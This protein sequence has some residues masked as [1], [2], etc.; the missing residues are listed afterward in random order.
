MGKNLT[1]SAP[2]V[3]LNGASSSGKT[4]I[5]RALQ[6][7]WPRP[8]VLTGIDTFILA[9]PESFAALPGDDGSPAAPSTGIRIVPGLGPAPSWIPEFG[10][11]FHAMMRLV[12]ESW[13]L[14]SHGGVDQVIDHVLINETLRT[15]AR[16]ILVGA[17]WVGVSCDVDE[18]VRREAARGDRHVGFASGTSV[19]VHQEMV[20]DLVIDSTETPSEV[21]ARRVYDAVMAP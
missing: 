6:D 3:V 18:L 7:L 10:V 8:L 12:H 19:V 5:A 2:I 4:S 17:F 9:W 14:M 13:A 11:D 15:Q 16:D 21:L 20:Y 1:M